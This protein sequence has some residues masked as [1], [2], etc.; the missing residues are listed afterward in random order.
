MAGDLLALICAGGGCNGRIAP[1]NTGTADGCACDLLAPICAGDRRE[2]TG[3]LVSACLR[4]NA[5][6]SSSTLR[7]LRGSVKR[8]G[9]PANLRTGV[10]S[11]VCFYWSLPVGGYKPRSAGRYSPGVASHG[12]K[13]RGFFLLSGRRLG[14][15]KNIYPPAAVRA[16]ISL[17]MSLSLRG[18]K[19]K[20]PPGRFRRRVPLSTD[21]RLGG[22]NFRPGASV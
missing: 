4:A 2:K 22:N 14:G 11:A 12:R 17:Y 8:T 6:R 21:V 19:W 5:A 16:P 15:Y 13:Q 20:T 1:S 7:G 9:L 18:H 3:R 10:S